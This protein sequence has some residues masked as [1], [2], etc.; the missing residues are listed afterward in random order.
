MAE[1]FFC[2]RVHSG[3]QVFVWFCM[4]FLPN[5]AVLNYALTSQMGC[6]PTEI[7]TIFLCMILTIFLG[8]WGQQV[9]MAILDSRSANSSSVWRT[10]EQQSVVHLLASTQNSSKWRVLASQCI[11]QPFVCSLEAPRCQGQFMMRASFR[12]SMVLKLYQQNLLTEISPVNATLLHMWSS[13]EVPWLTRKL[14]VFLYTTFFWPC[15]WCF[16]VLFL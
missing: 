10:W 12:C 5:Q 1:G 4:K 9:E 15:R 8:K 16:L 13:Q 14:R 7:N 11:K 2:Q 6:S 3:M